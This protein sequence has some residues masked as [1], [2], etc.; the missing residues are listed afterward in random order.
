MALACRGLLARCGEYQDCALDAAT[1]ARVEARLFACDDCAASLK[2]YKQT[3]R[4]SKAA[5]LK[6]VEAE[7]RDLPE[8]SVSKD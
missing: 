2:G 3:I 6:T 4:L 1:R 5:F 8:A 7:A